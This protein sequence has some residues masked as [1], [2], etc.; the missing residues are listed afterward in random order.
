VLR[1]RKLHVDYD[2]RDRLAAMSYLLERQAEG[3]VVTGLL[4]EDPNPDD[5]ARSPEHRGGYRSIS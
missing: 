4:F 5:S 1:L 2:P 3:E